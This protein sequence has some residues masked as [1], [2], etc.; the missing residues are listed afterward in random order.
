MTESLPGT[1][2]PWAKGNPPSG[3]PTLS[4]QGEHWWNGQ[5]NRAGPDSAWQVRVSEQ[6]TLLHDHQRD[7]YFKFFSQ[8]PF[9]VAPGIE[10]SHTLLPTRW[11]LP[12]TLSELSA[13][14]RSR[15]KPEDSLLPVGTAPVP[16]GADL[17]HRH[18]EEPGLS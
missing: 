5:R 13:Q 9:L 12:V 2:C 1:W 11:T 15:N 6:M 7:V 17:E 4:E 8:T 14:K 3:P 10:E 16:T 18:N